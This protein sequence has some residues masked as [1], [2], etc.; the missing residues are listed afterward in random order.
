MIDFICADCDSTD[1]SVTDA[2]IAWD[3]KKQAWVID[4]IFSST[5]YCR[6]CNGDNINEIKTSPDIRIEIPNEIFTT[7]C[8]TMAVYHENA[9][10]G[11]FHGAKNVDDL[12]DILKNDNLS[13]I[14]RE[15]IKDF[16]RLSQALEFLH[17]W[18]DTNNDLR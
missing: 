6:E 16:I 11:F 5:S 14:D 2:T 12:Y 10:E 15:E 18:E 13:D 4:E 3:V 9:G 17:N 1:I 7:I 8:E